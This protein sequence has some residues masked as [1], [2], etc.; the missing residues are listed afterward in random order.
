[1]SENQHK[2]IK[3]DICGKAK[4]RTDISP[5]KAVMPPVAELIRRKHP[6]W[7]EDSFICREDLDDFRAEYVTNVIEAEMGAL[8][9]LE[10]KVV[11]SMEEQELVAKNVN[12]EFEGQLSFGEKIADKVASFGGSWSFI[13]TFGA[14]I[15]LWIA[16]NSVMLFHKPFDP[17]P[18]IL[19]NLMLSCLAAFQAPVIMMSQN[20]QESK[21]RLRAQNDYLIN[22]KS[23][24]EVRHLND[25]IDFLL[26]NQWQRLLEIQQ[27]QID[28][29]KEHL[30]SEKPAKQ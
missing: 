13:I 27:I 26:T 15:V 21:D 25:K 24:L 23:E 30:E 19:L 4:P 10:K 17:F 2:E 9:E 18:L 11:A 5:A 7:S 28:L 6:G 14:F 1:M 22:L 8:S 3:C 29:I 20:R 12:D 16:L